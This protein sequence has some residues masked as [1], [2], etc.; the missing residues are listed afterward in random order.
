MISIKDFNKRRCEKVGK[1]FIE[2]RQPLTINSWWFHWGDRGYSKVKIIDI[3]GLN[4]SNNFI[5]VD[6]INGHKL[7]D[8][9]DLHEL[10]TAR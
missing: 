10:I 7:I 3:D 8:Y 9:L 2:C 5:T 4:A 1:Q 6:T